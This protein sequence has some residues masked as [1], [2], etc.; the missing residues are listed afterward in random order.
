MSLSPE[1]GRVTLDANEVL[2]WPLFDPVSI[3]ASAAGISVRRPGMGA[4]LL[5]VASIPV[6]DWSECHAELE[7]EGGGSVRVA[8][9]GH[10]V[11]LHGVGGLKV[12]GL[13]HASG[14]EGPRRVCP[15]VVSASAGIL[16]RFGSWVAVGPGGV[17]LL[18]PSA[19]GSP[20]MRCIDLEDILGAGVDKDGLMEAAKRRRA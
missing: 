13:L 19:L 14:Q 16:G 17:A 3:E 10:N 18:E 12:L 7:A 8:L 5:G 2:R 20:R 4:R 6:T 11:L 1:A 15:S 9:G